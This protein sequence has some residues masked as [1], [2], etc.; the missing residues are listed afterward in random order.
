MIIIK[1]FAKNEKELEIR[2][3]MIR[4]FSLE[5]VIEFGIEKCAM[6][7]MKRG[8]RQV[9]GRELPNQEKKSEH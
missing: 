4:I 6:L 3:S 8:K 1:Q 9:T 7:L 5:I 2:I